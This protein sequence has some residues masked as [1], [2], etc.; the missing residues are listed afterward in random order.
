[1]AT[2]S[3]HF[4]PTLSPLLH[5]KP[6]FALPDGI[7]SPLARELFK[8]KVTISGGRP[9]GFY[10]D[11]FTSKAL[12]IEFDFIDEAD[13]LMRPKTF[14][15][16]FKSLL[17]QDAELLD[18]KQFLQPDECEIAGAR[19]SVFVHSTAE[20]NRLCFIDASNGPVVVGAG[21]K[22]GAFSILVGPVYIGENTWLDRA[23]IANSRIG[24]TCRIGGEISD[25]FI[26][27]FTNKHHEGFLGH[28]LIGDWV[29]LGALTTTS[30]LKNNYSRVRLEYQGQEYEAGTIKF[31]SIIGDFV[32]TAI[33]TMLNTGTIID[34]AAL[35]YAP[36]P[37]RK[38]YESF[39]W[40]G[41][42]GAIYDYDRFI[43]DARAIMK[44]RV[45][46]LSKFQETC[47][48][49]V[50]AAKQVI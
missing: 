45:Q 39:F 32:K 33:G 17:Q 47:L 4:E 34:T 12:D 38:Y 42:A 18:R 9:Q 23:S 19:E 36:F 7:F 14:L 8:S 3:D 15:D 10:E 20:V 22:I 6:A 1:M 48:Q 25:C 31:G 37:K 2:L 50:F 5:L 13:D 30:D 26:G 46:E 35:L 41:P 21:C 43:A 11:F 16:R 29:N 24:D 49:A 28:S 44:R 40:G 27:D